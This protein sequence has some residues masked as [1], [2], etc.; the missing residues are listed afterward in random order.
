MQSLLVPF[1]A[2]ILFYELFNLLTTG[3]IG[4]Y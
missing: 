1:L 4:H 3:R 2:F